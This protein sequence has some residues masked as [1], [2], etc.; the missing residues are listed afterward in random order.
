MTSFSLPLPS[1]PLGPPRIGNHRAQPHLLS[2]SQNLLFGPVLHVPCQVDPSWQLLPQRHAGQRPLVLSAS[3]QHCASL[4][5]PLEPSAIL[6]HFPWPYAWALSSWHSQPSKLDSGHW[7]IWCHLD[8]LQCY[9]SSG[10]GFSKLVMV[11]CPYDL[12]H[13][14]SQKEKSWSSLFY[15]RGTD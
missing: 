4:L 1:P 8:S 14:T 11:G 12:K 7:L 15:S 13:Y 10:P 2:Y 6:Y 3:S 9:S 5:V